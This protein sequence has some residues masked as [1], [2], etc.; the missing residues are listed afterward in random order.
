MKKEA[1]Q[2][3]KF[4]GDEKAG[5]AFLKYPIWLKN[6]KSHITDYEEKYRANMWMSHCDDGAQ[7]NIFGL[8]TEYEKAKEKLER[9]YGDTCKVI[10]ACTAEIKSHLQVHSFDYKGLLSLKAC[11]ES[12]YA[13]LICRKLEQKMSN[14]DAFVLSCGMYFHDSF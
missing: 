4:C 8:E 13:C 5:Q 7:K 1:V 3:P 10:H 12:N 9:Y 11:L 2:L 6:W 14:K